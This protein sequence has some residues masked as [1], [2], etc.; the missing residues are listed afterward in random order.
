MKLN[1]LSV[2]LTLCVAY[3]QAENTQLVGLNLHLQ[4]L[5]QTKLDARIFGGQDASPKQFPHQAYVIVKNIFTEEIL[6]SGT[7]IHPQW[8][9]TTASC[10]NER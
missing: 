10:L 9:L 6:C 1:F 7:L 3:V 5:N 2:L 4:S 8:I